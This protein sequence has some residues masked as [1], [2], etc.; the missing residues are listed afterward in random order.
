MTETKRKKIERLSRKILIEVI[1]EKLYRE[2]PLTSDWL[3]LASLHCQL[4]YDDAVSKL[5][6]K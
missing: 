3:E 5:K 6:S 4:I 1:N 2:E